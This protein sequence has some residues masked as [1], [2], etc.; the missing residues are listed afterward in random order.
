[1]AI[2]LRTVLGVRVALCA[3]ESD[4]EPGDVYL[5]DRDHYALA[6]KFR[7]DWYGQTNDFSYPIEWE[8]MDTQKCRDAAAELERWQTEN[9]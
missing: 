8:I 6:A 1:M 7:R 3:S 9:E 5:D 2:R 4:A